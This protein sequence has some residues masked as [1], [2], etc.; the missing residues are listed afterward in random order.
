MDCTISRLPIFIASGVV[1]LL[2]SVCVFSSRFFQNVFSRRRWMNFLYAIVFTL[3]ILFLISVGSATLFT[4]KD[5]WL[6]ESIDSNC[7]NLRMTAYI[8]LGFFYGL[9][10]C[11]IFGWTFS[12]CMTVVKRWRHQ[13]KYDF[14][15]RRHSGYDRS[16]EAT[17][18]NTILPVYTNTGRSHDYYTTHR[19]SIFDSYNYNLL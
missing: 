7:K 5:V 8:S 10:L 13:I 3:A 9:M 12:C 18:D 17:L 15:A 2:T 6:A 14:T 1:L 16:F 11:M 19:D 4:F